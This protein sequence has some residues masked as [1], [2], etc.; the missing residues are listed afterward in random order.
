MGHQHFFHFQK[1]FPFFKQS[2]LLSSFNHLLQSTGANTVQ[3]ASFFFRA[4]FLMGTGTF[5]TAKQVLVALVAVLRALS[6]I[7]FTL[8]H[9]LTI[10]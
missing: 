1:Y 4:C 5:R 2:N 3:S 10:I 7:Q 6:I 8:T 9:A